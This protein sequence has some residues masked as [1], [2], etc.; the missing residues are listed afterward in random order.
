ML[1]VLERGDRAALTRREAD[2]DSSGMTMSGGDER[3][4]AAGP[5]GDRAR[6]S[7]EG[8]D[9]GAAAAAALRPALPPRL[10][11]RATAAEPLEAVTSER[12]EGG[13][14]RGGGADGAGRS[15][16]Y[17]WDGA[18]EEEEEEEEAA[19]EEDGAG[20]GEEEE[21]AVALASSGCTS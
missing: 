19:E 1:A 12:G 21:E 11:R 14:A 5:S 3:E 18:A 20:A 9:G 6:F 8:D 2:G 13:M 15:D 10:L 4:L 17:E 16:E 7:D